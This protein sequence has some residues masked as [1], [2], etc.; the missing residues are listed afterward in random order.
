MT[1]HAPWRGSDVEKW[2]KQFRDAYTPGMPPWIALDDLLDDY[3]LHSDLG[4]PLDQP[5]E[6]DSC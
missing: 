4:T 5:V 1:N 2:I 3:R 6:E